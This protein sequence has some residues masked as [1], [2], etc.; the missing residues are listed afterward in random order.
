MQAIGTTDPAFY[1]G[2]I[3]H[4]VNASQDSEPLERGA[5]FML[6]VVKGSSR[7]TGRGDARRPDGRRAYGLNEFA[8]S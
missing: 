7:A 8:G 3:G 4:L 5:N 2:W 1:D 6:S